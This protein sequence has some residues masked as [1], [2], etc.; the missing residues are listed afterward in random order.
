MAVILLL[1]IFPKENWASSLRVFQIVACG[2]LDPPRGKGLIKIKCVLILLG[3]PRA[4]A[5]VF[6]FFWICILKS[7]FQ[8]H[9]TESSPSRTSLVCEGRISVDSNEAEVSCVPFPRW[10]D[11]A[12]DPSSWY[13]N[14]TG[15]RNKR[16]SRLKEQAPGIV[17]V[18]HTLV[19]LESV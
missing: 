15:L 12:C 8:Y 14:F 11:A 6:M 7:N 17:S 10:D 16:L 3:T 5:S 1:L 4:L 18:S 13:I 9:V 19:F 2:S